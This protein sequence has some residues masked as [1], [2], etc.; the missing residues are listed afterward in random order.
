[1]RGS[2]G[3]HRILI[4]GGGTAGI[5]V[6][7]RLG[8]AGES[9]IGL[10]EPSEQHFYQPLW[11]L[12]G[13]GIARAAETVR[14]MARVMP[15]GVSWIRG[16]AQVIDPESHHV[17]LSDG[18]RVGYDFLVVAPGIQID[19][20]AIAGLEEA[21]RTDHVASVYDI[22][23][24][25]RMARMVERFQGGSA[26]F[27]STSSPVK[28]GGAPQ[29]IMYLSADTWR[30][31]GV[32]KAARVVFCNAGQVIFGVQPFRDVLTGVVARYGIDVRH[33]HDLIEVLPAS[34]EA[35]FARTDETGGTVTLGYDLLHVTPRMSAPDFL[36]SGPLGAG[37]GSGWVEV[38]RHTLQH[39]RH[40]DVFSLGDA[41][42]VPTARTGAAI[43]KQAPVLVQNLRAAMA[44]R[45]PHARYNGYSSC[46]LLTARNRML[47][48]EFDYSGEPA[49]SIPF[50]NT[51]RERYSM[52]LLKRYGLPLLYWHGM[53]EGR[54]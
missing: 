31:S 14:P 4:I 28:C 22:G 21:L 20:D 34:R 30:R 50:L 43:R 54:V 32:L 19:W 23:S 2:S 8:R 44:G 17:E 48:A 27:T 51:F 53:L 18:R 7:A 12:V 52:Y 49:P 6:A 41:C 13:V 11:T 37:D 42:N 33:R 9:D 46:P 35:V 5:T 40:P 3:R 15:R 39:V 45:E 47:L 24:A 16:R 36:K 29:K 1:M 10:I 25:Q 38:D 26:L